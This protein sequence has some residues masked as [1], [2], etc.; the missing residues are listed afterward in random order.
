MAQLASAS[1][2]GAEGRRFESF[3]P[4]RMTGGRDRA[5]ARFDFLFG[6]RI[7]L[8]FP[9]LPPVVED[10]CCG[11]DYGQSEHY[12]CTHYLILF[13]VAFAIKFQLQL[14]GIYL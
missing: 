3:Y 4:D 2:L 7:F 14:A 6:L 11:Y 5:A 12:R 9:V 8:L 10:G 1:A 13:F